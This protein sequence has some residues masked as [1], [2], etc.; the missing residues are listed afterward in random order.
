[1]STVDKYETKANIL[2]PAHV[3]VRDEGGNKQLPDIPVLEVEFLVRGH[4]LPDALDIGVTRPQPEH[5]RVSRGCVCRGRRSECKM[6]ISISNWRSEG[7][8]TD[9]LNLNTNKT[10][11]LGESSR[12]KIVI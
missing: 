12:S 7:A 3:N 2:M 4:P 10:V 6:A 5:R 8:S 9:K 11:V 1:M